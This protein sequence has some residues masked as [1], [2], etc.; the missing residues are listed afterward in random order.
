MLVL[1]VGIDLCYLLAEYI[2]INVYFQEVDNVICILVEVYLIDNLKTKLLIGMDVMV[3]EG[4]CLDFDV[5][6]V[7]VG[8]YIKL[9]VLILVYTKLYYIPKCVVY[10]KV[11]IVISLCSIVCVL[12]CVKD[13]RIR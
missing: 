1:V 5:K 8:S 4:F 2:K 12:V 11:Q 10:V 3:Y 13:I 6:I 9:V 7:K